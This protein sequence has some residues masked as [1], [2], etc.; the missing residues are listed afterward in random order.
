MIRLPAY[1]LAGGRSR[2][3]GSDKARALLRDR[4]MILHVAD[5]ASAVASRITV[6]ADRAGKYDDLGLRTVSDLHGGLGPLAG[7]HA[8]LRDLKPGEAWLL[9][10]PCDAPG[11]RPE[12]LQRLLPRED[13]PCDVVALCDERPE[14][15][16]AVFSIRCL[17]EVERR[18]QS[19]QRSLHGLL[20]TLRAR[21][22]SCPELRSRIWQVN[23]PQEL[24]RLRDTDHAD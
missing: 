3:F 2:R 9:L 5:A 8:A 12:W 1:I 23:T 22:A 18:L 21:E 19:N 13:D 17:P 10:C 4:P 16:P 24:E 6:V 20:E 14:P 7:L 15:L 11:L